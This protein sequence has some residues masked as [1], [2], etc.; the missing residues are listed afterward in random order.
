MKKT[1]TKPQ[2][3]FDSFELSQTIARCEIISNVVKDVCGWYDEETDM[4]VFVAEG[5]CEW[6]P[7]G[8]DIHNGICYHVP[9]EAH[10][11]FSS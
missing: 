1:Y 2:I 10:N 4:N 3:A 11:L 5:A 8:D 9:A 6:V 7:D